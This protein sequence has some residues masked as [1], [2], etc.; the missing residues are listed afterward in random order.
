MQ[1]SKF[2]L[3]ASERMIVRQHLRHG[4]P[5]LSGAEPAF[6]RSRAGDLGGKAPVDS[7]D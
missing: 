7:L 6:W 1:K 2:G 3:E 4:S 5:W